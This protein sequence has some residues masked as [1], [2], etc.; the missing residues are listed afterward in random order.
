M[1]FRTVQLLQFPNG[2][3]G[4][5]PDD[6]RFWEKALSL[7]IALSPHMGFGMIMNTG[8]LRHDTSQWPAEAGMTQHAQGMPSST[9]AQMIVHGVFDRIPELRLYFAEINAALLP[10]HMYYMD[11]DYLEYNSWFQLELPRLPSEYLRTHALYGMVREPLAIRMGQELPEEMPLELFL[12]GS[13]FPHS[14]GTFPRSHEYIDKT[15]AELDPELRHKLLVGNAAEHL[16]LDLDVDIT[17]TPLACVTQRATHSQERAPAAQVPC[18]AASDAWSGVHRLVVR[19]LGR[20]VD[21]LEDRLPGF[22]A[23]GPR[24]PR[25]PCRSAPR[26]SGRRPASRRPAAGGSGSSSGAREDSTRWYSASSPRPLSLC[27]ISEIAAPIAHRLTRV[28]ASR[29]S[30]GVNPCRIRNPMTASTWTNMRSTLIDPRMD[31]MSSSGCDRKAR[32]ETR[33]HSSSH[34]GQVWP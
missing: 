28:Y 16:G 4:P 18:A 27:R 19:V 32:Y 29:A 10:A 7:G 11:R 5:K 20:G 26:T 8:G 17:E 25:G 21:E 15:F 12:W 3:P 22:S 23:P 14:V 2:G 9:M 1:G 24:C 6:D 13:D 34:S 30:T 31:W 33:D